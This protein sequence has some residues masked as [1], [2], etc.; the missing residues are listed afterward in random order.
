[1]IINQPGKVSDRILLLGREESSVYILKGKDEY[2]LIGGGMVH[3]IPE[4]LEQIK[5]FGIEEE[6]ITR[7]FI[8]HSHFDHCGVIPFFKRRWPHARVTA[9]AKAKELL[10]APKV[11]QT[12]ESLNRGLI[13]KY[14][15]E[16]EAEELDLGFTGITVEDVVKGGDKLSC[17]DLTMEVIDVPGH[18][19][20]SIAV[21]V[22]EEKAM[23]ASDA[24][25]IPFG[26]RVF[27]AANSNFD[28]YQE[29]L[30]KMA[31]YD[32]EIHL[33]EHYGARTGDEGRNFLKEAIAAAKESR[34]ILEE[35]LGRNQ[36]MKKSVEEI[37]DRVMAHA[38][39]N[40]LPRDIISIVVGQMLKY[41]SK[42]MTPA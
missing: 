12:V 27:T 4:M 7:M 25:G 31:R 2:A 29:S 28:K 20:C 38:P 37:T 14:G 40:F 30:E 9:S 11:I 15:R 18:S 34:K 26:D 24:G 10:S 22:P 36:D 1:M 35:T 23:F 21:Y 16:K 5:E 39:D 17:G 8:L 19:S 13:Q 42:Q 32:I 6:K 41:L 3:A 33:A